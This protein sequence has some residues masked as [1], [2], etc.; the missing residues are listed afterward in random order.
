MDPKQDAE[1]VG[2]RTIG[3]RRQSHM[4]Q[5]IA[6]TMF[7]DMDGNNIF[8]TQMITPQVQALLR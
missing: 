3:H 7:L 6:T 5:S 1:L 8:R 4:M 2:S